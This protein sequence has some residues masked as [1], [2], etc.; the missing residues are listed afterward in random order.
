MSTLRRLF[1]KLPHRTRHR[2]AR[3]VPTS[4]TSRYLDVL[5]PP[6]KSLEGL[7]AMPGFGRHMS[8]RCVEI[9]WALG[10]LSGARVVL[11]VGYANAEDVYV[12]LLRSLRIPE[13]HGLDLVRG[14]HAGF[15]QAVGDVR[16]PPYADATFDLVTCI[17][18]LEHVSKDNTDYGTAGP[19][20]NDGGDLKAMQGLFRILKPGGRLI[21][22][23]PFGAP[24][25]YGWQIQYDAERLDQLLSSA[26]FERVSVEYFG[27]SNGWARC[28]AEALQAAEYGVNAPNAA[29]LV[30]AEL[31]RPL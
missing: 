27:Y 29:G 15:I 13:L 19:A 25:D 28:T 30:C 8:E 1:H 23:V 9:P 10:R 12:K 17:S 14:K 3:L 6:L 18:T 24:K 21:L 31:R 2:L 16:A 7:L 11:D 5:S 20:T 26:P 4:N 22:S